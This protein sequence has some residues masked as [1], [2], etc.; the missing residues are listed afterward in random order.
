MKAAI[1]FSAVS[2]LVLALPAGAAGDA[3]RGAALFAD[4]CESCHVGGENALNPS[5][6][7]KGAWFASNFPS[8]AKIFAT[9]RNGIPKTVMSPFSKE[10]L[11]DQQV[12]DI[13]AY[14]RTLTPPQKVRLLPACSDPSKTKTSGSKTETSKCGSGKSTQKKQP[15]K[16]PAGSRHAK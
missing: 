14:I 11:S 9:I 4:T 16:E 6:P 8:D 7:L 12:N 5:K 3:K 1:T 2:L 10:R 15:A 13:I